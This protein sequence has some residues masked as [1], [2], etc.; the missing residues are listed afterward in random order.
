MKKKF[1]YNESKNCVSIEIYK[2]NSKTPFNKILFKYERNLKTEM[3]VINSKNKESKKTFYLYNKENKLNEIKSTNLTTGLISKKTIGY[4]LLGYIGIEKNY[5][6]NTLKDRKT[7]GYTLNKKSDWIKK[8]EYKNG[9]PTTI[10][11]REYN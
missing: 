1:E 9:I 11:E 6:N 3:I 5:T 2:N 8:F 4:N 10:T 7:Y